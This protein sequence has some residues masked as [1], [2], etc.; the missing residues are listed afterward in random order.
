MGAETGRPP[1]VGN[2]SCWSTDVLLN[3]D[4]KKHLERPIIGPIGQRQPK[5]VGGRPDE[6]Y[7]RLLAFMSIRQDLQSSSNAPRRG[8]SLCQ[9]GPFNCSMPL[10]LE[11]GWN[12][13]GLRWVLCFF[14]PFCLCLC[15]GG[16][17]VECHATSCNQRCRAWDPAL[18]PA[19]EIS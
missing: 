17:A 10:Q 6:K 12:Q 15:V 7:H 9:V 8:H 3:R 14:F 5:P 18:G 11:P 13:V 19:L 4:P 1:G 16:N 2:R